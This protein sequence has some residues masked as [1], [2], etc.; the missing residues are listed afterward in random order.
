MSDQAL[1]TELE[2]QSEPAR[3]CFAYYD[4]L[5][6]NA[7]SSQKPSPDLS[8]ITAPITAILLEH[9]TF[10]KGR[11]AYF[12]TKQLYLHPHFVPQGLLR[13]TL[14]SGAA[15]SVN[16]LRRLFE[17]DRVG[18]RMVA[19][20]HGIEVEQPTLLRN[21]V[22]L[23]PVGIAPDSP[24]LRALTRRHQIN[25]WS[26]MDAA[27]VTLPTI[28]VLDMGIVAAT[29]N[30]EA[31][32]LADDTAYSALLD[33]ARALTLANRAAPVLGNSWI[34]FVDPELALAEF[35]R[36]WMGARFE[37]SMSQFP[38]KIDNDALT[39]AA[40]YLQTTDPLRPL[41]DV[42]LDRLNLARRRRSPGD[43]AIDSGICL[44]ALLGDD[45]PQELTYKLRLRAALLLGKTL[46]ERQEISE[47]VANLYRLRSKVVHGRARRP[48]D[49]LRDTQCASRGL[50]ICEQAVRA[51][52]L[53][54]TRP[55][56]AVWEM[57]GGPSGIIP[58]SS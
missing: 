55:D 39:W 31:G 41:L 44:E 8:E 30:S 54:G 58:Q 9:P 36:M 32:K 16:W 53:N 52:V 18:L 47:S 37:G 6:G 35:G 57:V 20:L 1:I 38:T 27:S 42:A 12:A 4:G 49:H 14:R 29:A 7:D 3:R 10:G 34:D 45:N 40:R 23:F 33:T 26:M 56:F 11:S 17:V 22:R 51:I 5:E 48:Q 21:G 15:S 46:A 50:E 19:A 13:M 28:A 25:P 2:R 43:Q 24:N